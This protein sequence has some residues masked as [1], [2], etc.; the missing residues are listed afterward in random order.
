MSSTE[1][2]ATLDRY[3]QVGELAD[4]V[5][6]LLQRILVPMIALAVVETALLF[7]SSRPGAMCFAMIALGTLIVLAVWKPNGIGLPL[8]PLFAFQNLMVYGL[9]VVTGHEVLTRY[10][11]SFLNDAGFEVLVFSCSMAALWRA[12]MQVFAP[13]PPVSYALPDFQRDGSNKLRRLGF[14]LIL[15]G[16]AYQILES[17]DLLGPIYAL[18]PSGTYS[19]LVPLVTGVS[20]CGFFL[21]SLFVGAGELDRSGRTLFWTMLAVSCALSAS[22]FLLSASMTMIAS[23]AIGLFWSR[24][25]I[26]WRYLAVVVSLL[27]FFS[28]SKF[29]MRGRYWQF[30][31]QVKQS[32]I[33]LVQVP[34]IYL[35]WTLASYDSLLNPVG[36]EPTGLAG[37]EDTGENRQ[38]L[39]DRINNLQNLLYVIDIMETTHIPPLGGA[40]YSLIP[41][42]LVP[43]IMWPNKP[44]SHEGQVMLNVYFGRQDLNSTYRT[45]VAWGLLPEAYGNYGSFWG[46]LIL[47]GFLGFGCAWVENYTARKLLLSL[48]GFV[49]FTVLLAFANS[50]EMVASVF[51]TMTFQAIVP[52]VF[53]SMPFLRRM[54]ITRPTA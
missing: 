23:V 33:S 28:L 32:S 7:F 30:D 27:A 29:T 2:L 3:A 15:A 51:V 21:V 45:Y 35:E 14:S 13:S 43:R 11:E 53:A 54:T 10:P 9:P 24:G 4:R 37:K 41:P 46:A 38:T 17:A 12:G 20:A 39:F 26:P 18:L 52:I 50:F 6:R 40:T 42:L 22:G 44:R 8:V 31:D 48:E 25:A 47:G 49:S 36:S 16:T 1:R 34:G 19:L 5:R